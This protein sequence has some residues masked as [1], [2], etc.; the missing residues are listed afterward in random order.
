[1]TGINKA[2]KRIL[3]I[4]AIVGLISFYADIQSL[5]WLDWFKSNP[6]VEFTLKTDNGVLLKNQTATVIVEDQRIGQYTSDSIGIIYVPIEIKKEYESRSK[7][8]FKLEIVDLEGSTKKIGISLNKNSLII[9]TKI[10]RD[11]I[12][13]N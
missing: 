2:I 6:L 13:S 3:S 4:S 10:T 5:G 12:F 7:L 11:A 9:K 8:N 1:M